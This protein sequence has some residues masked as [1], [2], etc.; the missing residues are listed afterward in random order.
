MREGNGRLGQ[1]QLNGNIRYCGSP[2]DY[3]IKH[4]LTTVLKTIPLLR[5]STNLTKGRPGVFP[6][7]N[8]ISGVYVKLSSRGSLRKL[9]R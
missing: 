5:M 6:R 1:T 4:P 9:D 2:A 7:H 3:G 8:E